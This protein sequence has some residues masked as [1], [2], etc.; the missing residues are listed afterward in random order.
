MTRPDWPPTVYK[1][2]RVLIVGLGLH[3]GG[4]AA[5]RW[6]YRRGAKVRVTDMKSAT[7]LRSSIAAL[8]RYRLEW[9]LGRHRLADFRWADIVVQN[10]GVPDNLPSLH[11]ARRQ[12]KPI[13]NEATVFF[14]FCP[15]PLLAVTGTRGKTTTTL[16]LGS[17]L[18]RAGR[19][20]M[21]S[22]NVRQQP[23]LDILD[24]LTP[25]QAVVLE[26]S[27]FQLELCRTEVSNL[28][29]G[30]MTNL[31]IDHLNRYGTL[32]DYATAKFN[33]FRILPP[34]GVAVLNADD[35]WTRLAG[36]LVRGPI[37]WFSASGRPAQTG[38]S[39]FVT[40]RR[41]VEQRAGRVT[42]LLPLSAIRLPGQHQR[43]NVVAAAAAARAFGL[44]AADIR[45]AVRSF[46]GVPHRQEFVRRWRGHVF[47]NDTT[48][49]S[50]DGT[51][52]A[53]S[54][55]PRA[56]F[57]VGGTDK[58]LRFGPLASVLA[59]RR[60]TLVFLP[61]SASDRLKRAL[62]LAG[63]RGRQAEA[64]SMTTAVHR[65]VSLARS[66]QPIVLSPGAASF[67]LFVH[68]FDRGEQFVRAVKKL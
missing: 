15:S 39:V 3:G 47:V 48:A 34:R 59:A 57:I 36:Q 64:D 1:N 8:K 33:L 46:R 31:R 9:R 10:P 40:G 27:S 35:R 30:L 62:R 19:R 45:A 65:A 20:A 37:V 55:F 23:M 49:T 6:F 18:K 14:R 66:G 58:R 38:W 68:E 29:V 32:R 28:R 12:G 52:A 63:Y 4:V 25:A 26:L 7:E 41:I 2:K 56:V 5:A 13:V 42:T 22:G 21:V 60:T 61:G 43:A 50:P 51:L 17:M 53:L 67:G 44:R 24:G 11:W 54:V 16:L